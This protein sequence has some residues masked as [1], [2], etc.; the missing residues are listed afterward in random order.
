[1]DAV[2]KKIILSLLRNARTPQRR[3][4]EDVGISAQ[5]MNYRIARLKESGVIRRIALRVSPSFYGRRSGFAA[6]RNDA[7]DSDA[8]VSKFKC[9]EEVTIYEFA[10]DSD[11]DVMERIQQAALAVGEPVMTYIPENREAK[12]RIGEIDRRI[13]DT[14][15][16]D[17]TINVSEMAKKLFQPVNYIR[18]RLDLLEKNR[19]VAVIAE[20]DLTKIDAVLYSIISRNLNALLPVAPGQ[21]I[22]VIADRENG[23][24]VCYSDDLKNARDSINR[25]KKSDPGAEVMVVY[26]YEFR[27]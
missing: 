3:I 24:L 27:S 18:R 1:M 25:M 23:I 15:R 4:A 20:I 17:P 13:I 22:F 8:V 9:L 11:K 26:E 16:E 6:F 21:T 7:Y 2:D 5:S 19:M 10:A 12:M 14:L